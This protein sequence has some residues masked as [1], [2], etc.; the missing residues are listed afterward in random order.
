MEVVEE[1]SLGMEMAFLKTEDHHENS[2]FVKNKVKDLN[3]HFDGDVTEA[4]FSY[5]ANIEQGPLLR[6]RL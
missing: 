5:S 2:C 4:A 6:K 3:L 1:V